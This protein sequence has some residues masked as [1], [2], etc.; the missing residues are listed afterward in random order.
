MAL[1]PETPNSIRY[2]VSSTN[3]GYAWADDFSSQHV[4]N[5]FSETSARI[6]LIGHPLADIT[7]D[8]SLYVRAL[9]ALPEPLILRNDEGRPIWANKAFF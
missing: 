7:C 4:R 1:I 5:I 3:G 8:K 9:D 2:R 6:A